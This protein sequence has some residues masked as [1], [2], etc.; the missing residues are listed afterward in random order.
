VDSWLAA[1]LMSR[2]R[3]GDINPELYACLRRTQCFQFLLSL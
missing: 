2:I 3:A 1:Q